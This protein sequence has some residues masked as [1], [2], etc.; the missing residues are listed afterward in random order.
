MLNVQS[1]GLK[2]RNLELEDEVAQAL[3]NIEAEQGELELLRNEKETLLEYLEES[4][5]ENEKKTTEMEKEI[6]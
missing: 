5:K 2:E 4:T 1:I 3:R 6:E